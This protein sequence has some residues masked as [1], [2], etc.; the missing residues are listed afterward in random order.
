MWDSRFGRAGRG[1][2]NRIQIIVRSG[3]GKRAIGR[4]EEDRTSD[5]SAGARGGG[6]RNVSHRRRD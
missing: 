2:V 5:L 6:I 3:F 1:G 4:A